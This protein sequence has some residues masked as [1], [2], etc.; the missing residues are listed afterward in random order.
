MQNEERINGLEIRDKDKIK[1]AKMHWSQ[2][3][4]LVFFVLFLL[5]YVPVLVVTIGNYL[6]PDAQYVGIVLELDWYFVAG[7]LAILCLLFSFV[8]LLKAKQK[9]LP[10]ILMSILLLTTLFTF[11]FGKEY[12]SW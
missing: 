10:I 3:I 7:P 11:I 12:L 5:A 8:A 9:V 6:S 1:T 2:K 4:A